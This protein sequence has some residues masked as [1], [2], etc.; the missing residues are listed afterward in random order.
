MIKYI[1]FFFQIIFRIVFIVPVKLMLNHKI[2]ND[3]FKIQYLCQV[4]CMKKKIAHK[5]FVVDLVLPRKAFIE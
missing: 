1:F 4:F 3:L 5:T 2:E